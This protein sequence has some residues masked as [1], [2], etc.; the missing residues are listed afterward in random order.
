MSKEKIEEKDPRIEEA[1]A[2]KELMKRKGFEIL[3]KKWELIKEGAFADLRNETFGDETLKA[4]QIVYNQI[5]E[6]IDIPQA[7]LNEGEN[8][9]QEEEE[10]DKRESHPIKKAIKF[11]RRPY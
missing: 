5:C 11:I 9:I 8:A 2:I 1:I 6:W 4:R 7:I 10:E 3:K